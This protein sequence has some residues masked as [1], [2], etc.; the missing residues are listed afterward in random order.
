MAYEFKYRLNSAPEARLDGSGMIA[1][2]IWAIC[3]VDGGDFEVIPGR[4][5]TVNVPSATIEAALAQS[6]TN[7]K[8]AAYKAALAANLGT[9]PEPVIGWDV[10]SLT[11]VMDANIAAQTQAAAADAFIDGIANYPVDFAY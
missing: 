5:K 1:H 6:T 2:D 8:V 10:A 4:H 3:S 7:A 9:Q 11:A